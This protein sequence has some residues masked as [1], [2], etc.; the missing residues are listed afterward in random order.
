MPHQVQW[1][2]P[3]DGN[4]LWLRHRQDTALRA[5][6]GRLTGEHKHT[7]DKNRRW[8]AVSDHQAARGSELV[9]LERGEIHGEE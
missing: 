4:R 9:G 1:L 5:G 6:V 8:P 3:C 7:G 2:S